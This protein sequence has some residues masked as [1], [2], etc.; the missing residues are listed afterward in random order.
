SPS[1]PSASTPRT[2]RRRTASFVPGRNS[3]SNRPIRRARG[4]VSSRASSM[5]FVITT[6]GTLDDDDDGDGDDDDGA[7]EDPLPSAASALALPDARPRTRSTSAL[8]L[9]ASPP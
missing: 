5:P 7:P 4:L 6:S 8:T 3:A 9:S 2:P 1:V